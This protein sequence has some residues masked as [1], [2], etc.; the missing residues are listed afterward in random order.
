MPCSPWIAS[1]EEFN[2]RAVIAMRSIYS[3]EDSGFEPDFMRSIECLVRSRCS[4]TERQQ[5]TL[6]RIVHRRRRRLWDRLLTDF[7]AARVREDAR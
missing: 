1:V 2:H 6:Y 5:Q 3:A 7:A 4:L